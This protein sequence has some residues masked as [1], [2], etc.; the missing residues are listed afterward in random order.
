[1]T[2]AFD[3]LKAIVD[4]HPKVFSASWFNPANTRQLVIGVV[5]P[6]DSAAIQLEALR[7][8]VDPEQK[9]TKTVPA[10]YSWADMLQMQRWVLVHYMQ[11][12]KYSIQEVG[13]DPIG[14]ALHVTIYRTAT[15]PPLKENAAV[16]ALAAKYGDASNSRNQTA[17]LR[18]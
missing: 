12:P 18:P 3:Q 9:A 2:P 14:Q 5:L 11:Q 17:S 13:P 10:K 16:I 4:A 6:E 8:E 1:M 7:R 15:D